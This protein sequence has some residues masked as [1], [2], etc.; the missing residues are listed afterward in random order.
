LRKI[1]PEKGQ[2]LEDN[3]G[4]WWSTRLLVHK[5]LE[6]SHIVWV[7]VSGILPSM[8]NAFANQE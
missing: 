3:T 4:S 1:P 7:C 2:Q 5:N 6:L 8:A